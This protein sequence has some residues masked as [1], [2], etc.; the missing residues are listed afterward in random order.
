MK[1]GDFGRPFL[2]LAVCALTGIVVV[3]VHAGGLA[4][5]WLLRQLTRSVGTALPV[6]GPGL[7]RPTRVGATPCPR[8]DPAGR[9]KPGPTVSDPSALVSG[10]A[11]PHRP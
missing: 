4:P 6:V 8:P 10:S 5:H 2:W 9:D 11:A 7:S 1:K 3:P